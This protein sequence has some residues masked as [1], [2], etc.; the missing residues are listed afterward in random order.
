MIAAGSARF[1]V[2]PS[3]VPAKA[4]THTAESIC[5]APVA[6]DLRNNESLW[7]WV[8]AFAGTTAVFHLSANASF[9]PSSAKPPA[10]PPRS[11]AITF[12]RLTTWSRTRAANR[13]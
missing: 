10:K 11:H 8:P 12:G 1:F 5:G 4:G 13:P 6:D 9:A 3:V 7:L 2:A